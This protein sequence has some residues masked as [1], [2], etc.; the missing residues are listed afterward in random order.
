MPSCRPNFSSALTSWDYSVP[1]KTSSTHRTGIRTG[2]FRSGPFP[3]SF[4][5]L[6]PWPVNLLFLALARKEPER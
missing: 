5:G 2:H 1:L 6:K 4:P 3:R